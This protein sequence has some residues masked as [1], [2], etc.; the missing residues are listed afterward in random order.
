M[1][2]GEGFEGWQF[3]SSEEEL[4][5]A[6]DKADDFWGGESWIDMDDNMLSL[7]YERVFSGIITGFELPITLDITK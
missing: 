1:F 2:C 4:I 7:W 3:Y 6:F 5:E